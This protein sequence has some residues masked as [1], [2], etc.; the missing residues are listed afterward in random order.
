MTRVLASRRYIFVLNNYTDSEV[1]DLQFICGLHFSYLLYGKETS[2]SGTP[3]LQGYLELPKK[4]SM[5]TLH[6]IPGLERAALKVAKGSA[7]Q[8]LVY[9]GKEDKHPFEYGTPIQQGK[10]SD[11]LA[12]KRKIDEGITEEELWQQDFGTM[13]YNHRA[14]KVYKKTI[15]KPRD[16]ISRVLVFVGPTDTHKSHMAHM[17]GL[18]GHFGSFFVVPST[19]GSGLYFDG[20]D[21]HECILIDEMDGNRC[22]PTFL[23][24]LCDRY[25]FSVPVHGSGN[26]NFRASTIIICSNYVPKDW[27]KKSHNID[28][29]MRRITLAWFTGP[30]E[31]EPF[32]ADHL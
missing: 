2:A 17:L 20:Y 30:K 21:D 28:P 15:S 1:A 31:P 6:K 14:L 25:E 12:V 26:V 23:N 18:S 11:L 10:R 3:H 5:K 19:K 9:S 4:L 32:F 16:F 7:A 22:T 29:F 24:S 27:W 13:L 8:N